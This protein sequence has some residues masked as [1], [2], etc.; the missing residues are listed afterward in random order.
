MRIESQSARCKHWL[1]SIVHFFKPA[2][3]S[4]SESEEISREYVALLRS[5]FSVTP[6]CAL[7]YQAALHHGSTQYI[8]TTGTHTIPTNERLE[9]LGDAVLNLIVKDYLFRHYPHEKEGILTQICSRVVSRQS[10]NRLAHQH[11]ITALLF[12]FNPLLQEQKRVKDPGGNALEAIVGA[13]YLDQGFLQAQQALQH[14]ILSQSI[15]WDTLLSQPLDPKTRLIQECTA[16][17]L[18]VQ[19]ATT[20]SP[21]ENGRFFCTL[22]INGQK[23]P[24]APGMGYSKRAAEKQA[25]ARYLELLLTSSSS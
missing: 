6:R 3:K 24:Q 17:H 10:L 9:F 1:Q 18:T 16:R 5:V 20:A 11:G 4:S 15:A 19:F 7:Y 14:R 21:S 23:Q 22:I 25:A 12:Q 13:I 2:Q 8:S